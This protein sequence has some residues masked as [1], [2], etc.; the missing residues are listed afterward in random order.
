MIARALRVLR[1]PVTGNA[2][3][4][5]AAQFAVTVLPLLTLPYLAR[6]LGA[7]ELGIVVF[8]QSFSFLLALIVDF[9][10]GL[11][12]ARDVAQRRDDPEALART[13]AGVQGAKL[14]LSGI[15]ALVA[16][17]AVPLVPAFRD[18]PELAALGLVLAVIGALAPSWFF[19][20]IEWQKLPATLDVS[21]R[22]LGVVAI[23]VL[24]DSPDDGRLVLVI[25]AVLAAAITGP[26]LVLQ[27]RR[28]AFRMPTPA[29]VGDALRRSRTLFVSNLGVSLYTSANVFLLGLL[30]P[31][32]QVALF[33][34]A[35]KII[36][37]GTRVL[38][39]A[40]GAA[41]PRVSHLVG[42]GRP[43][44]ANRLALITLGALGSAA[45]AC[46]LILIV[47]APRI[48]ELVFG[49]EFAPAVG[50]LRVLALVLPLSIVAGLLSTLWLLPR[51]LDWVSTRVVL[52]S[53]ALNVAIVVTLVPVFGI[54]AAAWSLVAVE[55]LT[56][57]GWTW[58]IRRDIYA[59]TPSAAPPAPDAPPP[60]PA[61]EAEVI[62]TR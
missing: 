14:L 50:V 41:Y 30:V 18:A 25:Y 44:R 26:L 54:Q 27:Y 33:A 16:L 40:T 56:I 17:A 20:G 12:G 53:G 32:A 28:V 58:T 15:C 39:A 19:A 1:H 36:R 31:S 13:V 43:E 2:I 51:G 34:A 10:F 52:L 60:G 42:A 37:A 7:A 49:P 29:L 48:V 62:G 5:Y 57:A 45:L 38:G 55:L 24:V 11:S 46:A 6:V 47:F 61:P 8:V 9:A 22:V 4:L 23:L 59:S 35:E 21:M 3:A